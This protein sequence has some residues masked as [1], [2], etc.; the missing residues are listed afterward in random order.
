MVDFA[1]IEKEFEKTNQN[2]FN[3][4]QGELGDEMEHYSNLFKS[5]E[6][7]EQEVQEIKEVLFHFETSNAEVFSLQITE[8]NSRSEMLKI[9]RALNNAKSLYNLIRLSGDYEMLDKLDFQMLT[10]LSTE[11]N[12][13]QQKPTID[14]H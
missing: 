1:D 8:I 4:L 9:T 3:E 6:E 11:A 2:Y 14:W 13:S 10:V 7:I 12:R 5:H